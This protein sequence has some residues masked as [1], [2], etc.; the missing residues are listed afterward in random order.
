MKKGDIYFL[1]LSFL[2]LASVLYFKPEFTGYDIINSLNY[3]NYYLGMNFTESSNFTVN[4][5]GSLSS[6]VLSGSLSGEG[7]SV[8]YFENLIIANKS[9]NCTEVLECNKI[10]NITVMY[11][12]DKITNNVSIYEK[13]KKKIKFLGTEEVINNTF[14]TDKLPKEKKEIIFAIDDENVSLSRDEVSLCNATKGNFSVLECGRKCSAELN[15]SEIIFKDECVETCWLN[16]SYDKGLY[17]ITVIVNDSELFLDKIS[18]SLF[19]D[20]QSESNETN[21]TNNITLLEFIPNQTWSKDKFNL[22]AI[23][24]SKHFNGSDVH[25]NYSGNNF[26]NISIN[27]SLVSFYQ[28][29]NWIGNESV[30]FTAYNN[31]SNVS[32]NE[33]ILEVTDVPPAV[34]APPGGGGG[35]GGGSNEN[36]EEGKQTIQEKTVVNVLES[37]VKETC[38][39]GIRNQNEIGID[40]GGVC[41]ECVIDRVKFPTGMTVYIGN[42]FGNIA[43]NLA[44]LSGLLLLLAYLYRKLFKIKFKKDK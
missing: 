26:I 27:G 35:G 30:V 44:A 7:N 43:Y 25:Y 38:N 37:P 3:S 1:I 6:L 17:N 29:N 19:I 9:S 31:F 23:N 40:C 22:N 5:N 18:Y 42:I 21:I 36:E 12:G 13:G 33:V 8:V 10:R 2:I 28:Q 11:N 24:L 34:S 41:S 20:N 4:I 16:R 32:S 15:C 14:V 39:D